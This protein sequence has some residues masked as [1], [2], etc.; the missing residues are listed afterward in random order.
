MKALLPEGMT[1]NRAAMGFK[2]Q[3]QLIAAL[4]VANNLNIPFRKLKLEMTGPDHL[5]LGQAIQKLRSDTTTTTA[6]TEVHRAE[7]EADEDLKVATTPV[8]SKKKHSG[9]K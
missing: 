9:S 8:T 4:H 2:N 1:L 5:S 3:G 6:T 7:T